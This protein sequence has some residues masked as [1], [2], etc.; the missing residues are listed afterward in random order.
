MEKINQ[1]IIRV[2]VI[3]MFL[4]ITDTVFCQTENGNKKV[5]V[6]ERIIKKER[7]L[8][9]APVTFREGSRVILRYG[10]D[11]KLKGKI[12]VIYDSSINVGGN[13]ISINNIKRIKSFRGVETTIT[14]LSLLALCTNIRIQA[15][16]AYQPDY[17]SD[18]DD[19]NKYALFDIELVS[20]M[21]AFVGGVEAVIGLLR[22]ASA[23]NYVL[24]SDYKMYVMSKE[25]FDKKQSSMNPTIPKLIKDKAKKQE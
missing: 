10:D 20:M 3:L 5:L 6:I 2:V 25:E 16:H 24:D 4:F 21:F 14:G 18:G 19:M 7:Q 12:N 22:V 11:Q 13:I 8:P 1:Y 23:K 17:D 9:V 15:D